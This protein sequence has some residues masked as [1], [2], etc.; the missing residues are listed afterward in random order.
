MHSQVP[1]SHWRGEAMLRAGCAVFAGDAGQADSHRHWAHQVTVGRGEPVAMV[2]NDGEHSAPGFL[3]PAGTPHRLLPGPVVSLYL[4]ASVVA[5]DAPWAVDGVQT[6]QIRP[7]TGPECSLW[8]ERAWTALHA[9]DA[10]LSRTLLRQERAAPGQRE[11]EVRDA[12]R[13][14]VR[15]GE[16]LAR[17]TLARHVGVS[18]SRFSHWFAGSV[19]LPFRSYRKWMRLVAAMEALAGGADLT[20]AAHLAGFSDSAHL[21][22]T[23]R[24]AFGLSPSDALREV[25]LRGPGRYRVL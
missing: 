16:P 22:R 21:S 4:D 8:L 11:S 10:I 5:P 9:E 1:S 19:G 13:N 17:E 25:E 7:L 14:A 12:I 6:H 15:L 18:S 2:G 3:I 23:F 24:T 20:R